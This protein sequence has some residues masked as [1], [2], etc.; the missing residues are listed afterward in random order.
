M[1][2][3]GY[4]ALAGPFPST[5]IVNFLYPKDFVL[6]S[7][8]PVVESVPVRSARP[9]QQ[10]GTMGAVMREVPGFRGDYLRV[11]ILV[12]ACSFVLFLTSSLASAQSGSDDNQPTAKV[13]EKPFDPS[14]TE[15]T[16]LH[17]A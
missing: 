8:F 11:L 13:P 15:A 7:L 12:A 16:S 9:F 3:Q 6:C 5:Q 2:P 4:Q 17:T 1:L 14:S 10:A